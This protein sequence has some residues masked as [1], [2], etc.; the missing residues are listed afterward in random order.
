MKYSHEEKEKQILSKYKHG[1]CFKEEGL[2]IKT[3]NDILYYLFINPISTY[4]A[5]PT[6][7]KK[8]CYRGANRTMKDIFRICNY[9]FPKITYKQVVDML[10]YYMKKNLLQ[11]NTCYTIH[12]FV[13]NMGYSKEAFTVANYKNSI[14]L[15]REHFN[16]DT[17]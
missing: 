7:L 17:E 16:Y 6:Y 8:Q 13:L 15:F 2:N 4:T 14:T 5:Y 11:G 9:Y 12:Q 1:I 3:P 10:T